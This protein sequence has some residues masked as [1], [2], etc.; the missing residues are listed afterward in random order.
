MTRI[1]DQAPSNKLN[2][3]KLSLL[4]I[5]IQSLRH[6]TDELYLLLE[7]LNF[8]DIIAI[9]EH[10]LNIDEPVFVKN[11]TTVARFNRANFSHGGTMI[12]STNNDFSEVTKFNNLIS[13]KVFEFSIVYHNAYDLYIVCIYRTPDADVNIFCHKLLSLLESLPLRSKLILCGD[14]NIDFSSVCA[15]RECLQS[16]FDSFGIVMHINSPTRITKTSSSTID[17]VVSSFDPQSTSCTVLS[18]DL[19]DH[20]AVLTKF[21]VKSKIK[22]ASRKKCRV[23]SEKNLLKFKHLCLTTDWVM[24]SDD[25]DTEFSRFI[26]T[27]TSLAFESFPLRPIKIKQHKP[28]STKGL[29]ISAKNMRSL[30]HLKKFSDS[31]FFH[32]YVKLYRKVYHRAI[33]AA[34][35]N[36]YNRRLANSGNVAKETWSIVNELRNKAPS[37]CAVSTSPENLNNFFVNVAKNLMNTI[38]PSRDP[39]SYL[40]AA[41]VNL[42]SFFLT[43]VD[44]AELRSTINDIKNKSSSGTDGLTLKMFSNLP[45]CTLNH[46]TTLINMSFQNGTFPNCLKTAIIIP[47]HKGGDKDQAS[48]YRPIALLPTLSKIIERL[49]KKRVLSFLLKYK[50]L[51]THQFGF[52]SGK[53]TNDAIFSLLNNVYSSLNNHHSTATIFCDF[54]K[55]F[56]CVNHNILINKLQYYGFRGTPL[57]WF[58]SYLGNRSQ[59]VRVDTTM[60]SCMPI[61]CGVPQGSVLGPILFLLFINDIANLDISGKICLFADDTS[62]TWSNPDVKALHTTISSDL[63]TIKSWCDSNFLCLNVS[64]TKVLSYKNTL[65]PFVLNNTTIDVVE[66]VKFLG[67]VVDNSLKWDLH[68]DALSKKLSSACFALRSVSKELNL[69]TSRTV[70]CALFESHLRYAL[71]FWGTCCATQFDRIFRLQKRAV[72]YLLGLNS[73]THCQD[74]FKKYKIFT[75]PSLFIFESVCLVR[76]HIPAFI[77]RPSHNYPLRNAEHD[78]YLPTPRSE[79]VKGSILYNAKKMHN[80]LPFEIKS[81][82][83]FPTFRK[84]LKS[85]LLERA[86]YAVNDFYNNI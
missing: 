68:I 63:I 71:P 64:K 22:N 56:D 65:Q 4:L 8:P 49:V 60:S 85:Y 80:H 62:F 21:S 83:S 57:E 73:R 36:Y 61:E 59:F 9:T 27:L 31:V 16:I 19:S 54:S 77:E 2:D 14:L 47:L 67:L 38:T 29:R 30:S 43:P 5:N 48:N 58:K 17:Y 86:F 81:I 33:K 52:L 32:N 11:Y 46:L 6:K 15:A 10:W 37:S 72:R 75:L 3:S 12:M 18:T 42:H 35:D 24:L 23:L 7:E 84:V 40:S 45:E 79:L 82:T 78:L 41:N 53:C 55:A 25:V 1:E 28:W 13:E 66:S 26:K 74:F 20:E 69:S 50:I 70:Y 34:K 76:K 39:L 44:V 51:T